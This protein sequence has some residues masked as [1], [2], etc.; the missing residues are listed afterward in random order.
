MR[1]LDQ[2]VEVGE[3]AED[4]IDAAIIG[5]VVTEIPHRRGEEG[6]QPDRIHPEAR[7]IVELGGDAWQVADAVAVR[8]GEAARVDLVD[9]RA[10]PP[11]RAGAAHRR[12]LDLLSEHCTLRSR[13][14]AGRRD[15]AR[16]DRALAGSS[17]ARVSNCRRP[18][19]HAHV[20]VDRRRRGIE[21][22]QHLAAVR[23][24]RR[25]TANRPGL[26]DAKADELQSPRQGAMAGADAREPGDL[27]IERM[28]G[29][30]ADSSPWSRSVPSRLP[31]CS[32]RPCLRT[33][34]AANPGRRPC[35]RSPARRP[36]KSSAR[37]AS[38]RSMAWPS[39]SRFRSSSPPRAS[40][41]T[42][43]SASGSDRHRGCR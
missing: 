26:S 24:S 19:L 21:Q 16:R 35:R 12:P 30:E 9:R 38:V 28:I 10:P 20:L 8:I 41:R 23:G 4:R 3:R 39:M 34:P 40:A 11:G 33:C 7:D 18:R 6:R 1:A 36:N 42:S 14:A 43:A 17:P 2:R 22:Q 13:A 32:L 5:D 25:D 29:P 37:R 27:A 31:H 15:A